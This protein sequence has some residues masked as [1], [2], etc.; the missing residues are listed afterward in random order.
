[1][2]YFYHS[3]YFYNKFNYIY[4]DTT[5]DTKNYGRQNMKKDKWQ[6]KDDQNVKVAMAF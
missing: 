4:E 5:H 3:I 1:M 2:L 6:N